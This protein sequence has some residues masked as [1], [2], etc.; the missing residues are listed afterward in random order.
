[1]Y[2]KGS[3]VNRFVPFDDVAV[4]VHEDQVGDTDL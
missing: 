1:M 3:G 4:L 2:G